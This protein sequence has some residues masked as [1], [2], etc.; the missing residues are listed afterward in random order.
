MDAA[1]SN[2]YL[3]CN[4]NTTPADGMGAGMGGGREV[5]AS[6]ENPWGLL[7]SRSLLLL[8]PSV[9]GQAGRDSHT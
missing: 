1:I 8:S 7:V 6:G 4:N 9:A 2:P 5:E 3:I